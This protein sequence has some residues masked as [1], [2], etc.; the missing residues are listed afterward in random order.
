MKKS[1]L[2]FIL[3]ALSILGM[4]QTKP[5][6]PAPAPPHPAYQ[7]DGSKPFT[8]SITFTVPA[9]LVNYYIYVE[10]LGG[11]QQLA[12]NDKLSALMATN[13]AKAHQA[14]TDSL[15]QHIGVLYSKYIQADVAKFTA[16]TIALYHKK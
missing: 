14:L 8:V 3:T 11:A 9:Q 1:L 15:N 16:D 7:F 13:L 6:T 2:S 4:A 12:Y 10:Q 5:A